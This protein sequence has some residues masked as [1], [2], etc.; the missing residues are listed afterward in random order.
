MALSAAQVSVPRRALRGHARACRALAIS[1]PSGFS[2]P[3]G[4]ERACPRHRDHSTCVPSRVSVPRRALRGHARE[5]DQPS[6]AA[7]YAFQCPEG[8]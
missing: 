3:K 5:W 6:V 8:R 2:A 7:Q 4:V 1:G